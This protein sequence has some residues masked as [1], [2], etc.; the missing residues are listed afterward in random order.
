MFLESCHRRFT[1]VQLYPRHPKRTVEN[2]ESPPK[3]GDQG[4]FFRQYG[5]AATINGLTP[6]NHKLIY[7]ILRYGERFIVMLRAMQ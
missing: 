6:R 1:D 3:W 5:P 7:A 4:R 2:Y